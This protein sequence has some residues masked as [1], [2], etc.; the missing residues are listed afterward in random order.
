[1]SHTYEFFLPGDVPNK[2]DCYAPRMRQGKGKGLYIPTVIKDQIQ[3]LEL[4]IRDRWKGKAPLTNATVTFEFHIRSRRYD[5]DGHG[6]TLQ[7]CL[8][9][10]GVLVNDTARHLI[11]NTNKFRQVH[12]SYETGVAVTVT[13]VHAEVRK[14]S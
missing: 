1:M 11:E 6:S 5:L 9:N 8:V 14:A 12:H 4:L 7:D 2:K 10:A 3:L 13:G